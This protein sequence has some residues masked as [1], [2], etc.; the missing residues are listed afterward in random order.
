M[1]IFYIYIEYASVVVFTDPNW[2][3]KRNHEIQ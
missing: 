3:N 2:N 1:F